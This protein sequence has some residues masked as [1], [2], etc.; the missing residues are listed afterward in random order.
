MHGGNAKSHED[1]AE[2]EVKRRSALATNDV[3]AAAGYD[4]RHHERKGRQSDVVGHRYRHDEGEHGDEVHRPYSASHCNRGSHQPRATC[5]SP[6]GPHMPTEIEG[7]V[8]REAG[9]QNGQSD[10]I[11]IVYSGNDHRDSPNSDQ[12]PTGDESAD[13]AANAAGNAIE[14]SLKADVGRRSPDELVCEH[15]DAPLALC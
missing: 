14:A 13:S 2:N 1:T 8:R 4:N 15:Q 5:K 3:K 12:R 10:E 6:G 9:D 11:R 7:G